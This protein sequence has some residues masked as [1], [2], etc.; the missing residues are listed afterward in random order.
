MLS[1]HFGYG[2]YAP[3]RHGKRLRP[4][5]LLRIALAEG[6]APDDAL[7]AAAAIE[8]LHNYSL[9]HDDIEDA[10]ELRHGRRTLWALYGVAQA[11]NAGDALCAGS[12]LTLLEASSRQPAD[13]VLQLVRALHAS[14]AVMC[15]GQSLDLAFESA[16][17]VDTSAYYEMIAAKTAAL[18]G[19]ACEMGALCAPCDATAVQSYRNLGHAYGIAFQINDDISGIWSSSSATGKVS[20]HDIV[21]RKW[22]FPVV[23][24]L[25]GPP[26]I[27]RQAIERAYA[28]AEPLASSS[29]TDV[30]AA[31]EALGAREAANRAVAEH[32][33]I[34]ERHP[35]APVRDFL[36]ASLDDG[37]CA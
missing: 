9:V 12:F 32:L 29:V 36:L 15:E 3:A 28:R 14:H 26:S 23:W 25:A 37:G 31:L 19:A 24:A 17:R 7:D 20:G 10:D 13:R 30:V 22:T 2:R 27:A 11:L 21:R 18:F 1:Y 33:E 6:A 16:D 35:V 34:V 5:L 8:M 4:Q